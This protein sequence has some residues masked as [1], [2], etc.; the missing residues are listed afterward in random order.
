MENNYID[1]D[2]VMNEV[3]TKYTLST[4][5]L[6]IWAI[7]AMVSDHLPYLTMSL[8]A[9]YY[10]FPWF[11]M[12]AF[13]RITAPIFFYLIA[14]GYRRTRDPNRY[15]IRL[16]VFAFI[17]YVP[18][19][20]YFK[21]AA[22]GTPEFIENS[23]QLN[24][25]FTLLFGLLLLRAI[26][27]VKNIVMRGVLI[28]LCLIGGYFCDYGLYGIAMILICDVAKGSRRGTMLGMG[29]VV[30]VSVY[31]KVSD[32]VMG[33]SMFFQSIAVIFNP[34]SWM[35][36]YL[37]I[38]LCQLLPLIL[39]ARHRVWFPALA[40]EKRPGSLAKWG[41]YIFYPAH[42]TVLLLFRLLFL[43]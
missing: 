25:I 15:T 40:P 14:L 26:H 18:Y 10:S 7:I 41:F 11:I 31:V 23:L 20:W 21:N 35:L 27:E 38:L 12:H 16:F 43:G 39:I 24:I 9:Q 36:F 17:S 5:A 19:I 13:G 6:K 2:Q 4:N 42:I 28:V 1:E 32:W 3:D 33:G 29:A 30:M 8:Q 22:P 34:S 37:I